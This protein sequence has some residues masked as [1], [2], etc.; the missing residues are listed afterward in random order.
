MLSTAAGKRCR[1]I[2]TARGEVY[3]C[4]TTSSVKRLKSLAQ[5]PGPKAWPLVGNIPDLIKH[6]S[7][8]GEESVYHQWH[9]KYGPIYRMKGAGNQLTVCISDPE[10]AEALFR[11]EGQYPSRH[12]VEKNITWIHNKNKLPG[13]MFFSYGPEWK[14]IRS[15]AAKQVVPRRV[16]NFTTPLNEINEL[17][18]YVARIRNKDGYVENIGS[19][20]DMWAFQGVAYFVFREHLNVYDD[21]DPL[22]KE[23]KEAAQFLASTHTKIFISLPL[24]KIFPTKP[25]RNYLKGLS[26]VYTVGR[27]LMK[28]KYESIKE[29]IET[30]TVDETKTFGTCSIN[31]KAVEQSPRT[32]VLQD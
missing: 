12:I 3:R 11:A 32:C 5:L 8:A 14:R 16:G 7:K 9:L 29:A 18:Q 27:K 31:Q 1:W 21:T 30:G 10:S 6:M 20:L 2:L 15:A 28:K 24:Y 13:S 22:V 23:F 26:G 4:L 19:V 17:L 25:Y